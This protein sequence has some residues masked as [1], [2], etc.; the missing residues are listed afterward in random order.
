MRRPWLK[1]HPTQTT[2][3]LKVQT[4][5]NV[6]IDTDVPRAAT[7]FWTRRAAAVEIDNGDAPWSVIVF[8]VY[9]DS[10]QS[11][12]GSMCLQGRLMHWLPPYPTRSHSS[13]L[14]LVC[15][16]SQG[17]R[18]ARRDWFPPPTRPEIGLVFHM[19]W[20]ETLR[21]G[22]VG[23]AGEGAGIVQ[24]QWDW[25]RRRWQDG[26]VGIART[27][28]SWD[29]S[30]KPRRR[31]KGRGLLPEAAANFTRRCVP[32]IPSRESPLRRAGES[33]SGV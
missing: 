13:S 26:D 2:Q 19:G 12:K 20:Y 6:Q 18:G 32:T 24:G 9:P 28:W 4:Y 22:L 23:G 1:C 11:Q 21:D 25:Y 17:F 27:D 30:E 29:R 14:R 31:W 8:S 15:G 7:L 10:A 16:G 5:R 33:S 3:M